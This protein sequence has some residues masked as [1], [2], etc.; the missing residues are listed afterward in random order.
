MN[1]FLNGE[2]TEWTLKDG[3]ANPEIGSHE[4]LLMAFSH[5]SWVESGR[6]VLVTNLQGVRNNPHDQLLNYY[7]GHFLADAIASKATSR[8]ATATACALVA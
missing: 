8:Q 3:S 5:Y 2:Y 1:K 7:K 6:E 4:C